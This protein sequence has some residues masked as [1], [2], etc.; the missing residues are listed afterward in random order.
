MADFEVAP[1]SI[2][3]KEDR[4]NYEQS[5]FIQPGSI[6]D[7]LNQTPPDNPDTPTPEAPLYD[8]NIGG[9]VFKVP[10]EQYDAYTVEKAT[11]EA[12]M[13]SSQQPVPTEPVQEGDP[14]WKDS[15]YADPDA[16]MDKF[17][18]EVVDHVKEAVQQEYTKQGSKDQFWNDFYSEHKELEGEKGMVL[19][20][21]Q[22]NPSIG[23][24]PVTQAGGELAKQTKAELLRIAK[25]YGGAQEQAQDLGLVGAA[26]EVPREQSQ[27]QSDDTPISLSAALDERRKSRSKSS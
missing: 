23:D 1:D 19:Q 16:A 11:Q 14:D 20:I 26:Q 13:A 10:K 8:V 18:A 24:L 3:T 27:E 22:N 4:E 21:L 17:K 12:H 2:N 15:F 25:S 9:Q 7:N 5:A 6:L